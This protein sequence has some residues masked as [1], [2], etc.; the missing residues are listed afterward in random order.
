MQSQADESAGR[1]VSYD[2]SS[3]IDDGLLYIRQRQQIFQIFTQS[4]DVIDVTKVT[5][6]QL[7]SINAID[8][9]RC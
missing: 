8:V 3:C 4:I 5:I 9:I 1:L 2:R 7:N 6:S